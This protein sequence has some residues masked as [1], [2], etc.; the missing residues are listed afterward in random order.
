MIGG[1]N[2]RSDCRCSECKNMSMKGGLKGGNA[3]IPYPNGLVGSPWT[4]SSSGWPGVDG[5]PGDRNYLAYND[6]KVD[7]QTAMIST[8]A[9]P[10]FSVG[11]RRTRRRGKKHG[12]KGG[13]LTDDLVNLGRQFQF[14][15]GSAYN[16]LSGYPA[17]VNPLPW[18]GQ[19]PNTPSLN[20]V[21]VANM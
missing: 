16:A 7:P 21:R 1:K 9:N 15:V 20:A 12:Q 2:H 6:Y 11:G 4:P 8:G 13:F 17:P 14:G 19:L 10:P 5:I 3:G 18:K